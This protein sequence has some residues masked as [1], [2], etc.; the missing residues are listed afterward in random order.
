MDN[1]LSIA[2]GI[3]LI[4]MV[5]YGHYKGFIRLAVSAAALIITLAV[6]Q[7]AMPQATAFLRNNTQIYNAFESAMK[8]AVG[9]EEGADSVEQPAQQRN[10]IEDLSLPKQ[11]K[12]ALLENNNNEV[13]RVLGVETF[14][15]YVASYLTNSVIN[16]V[17]FLL[18]FFL[19]FAVLHVITS[20]L[21]LVARLP[22]ISGLNKIAGAALGAVEGLI[23]LWL[24]CL[25]ITALAG[26]QI[27]RELLRQIESSAWLSF[28]Y[29]HN[30][31][32]NAALAAM[33][34]LL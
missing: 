17:G 34:N 22:I 31:L 23:F 28:I 6:V 24:I 33:K 32:G 13:Y 21:N 29:D 11:L 3:F 19:V 15:E 16:I 27:G 5:L 25:I 10:I 2:A 7:A 14:T 18:L 9:I 30:L 12:Q 1:W 26:T 8:K 4:V 20:W